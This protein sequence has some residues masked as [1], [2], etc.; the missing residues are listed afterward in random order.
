MGVIISLLLVFPF[1]E[2]M[3]KL[4]CK[5]KELESHRQA[6]LFKYSGGGFDV[7]LYFITYDL[8]LN[9]GIRVI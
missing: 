9:C 6:F 5:C 4:P 1:T 3:L 8:V 7:Y 2:K